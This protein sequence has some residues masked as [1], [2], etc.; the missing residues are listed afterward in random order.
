MSP[1]VTAI[2]REAGT[3]TVDSRDA[4]AE[5]MA[6]L[7]AVPSDE[8]DAM[9]SRHEAF[10]FQLGDAVGKAFGPGL[11][12]SFASVLKEY[13][14]DDLL[15]VTSSPDRLAGSRLQKPGELTTAGVVALTTFCALEW[16]RHRKAEVRAAEESGD[17]TTLIAEFV[18]W[19]RALL[20]SWRKEIGNG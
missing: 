10:Y 3:I 16:L 12:R 19:L 6:Q 7:G 15:A 2:D 5:R 4:I 9:A 1:I 13:Y 20:A 17:Y 8:F 18:A 14:P 11:G